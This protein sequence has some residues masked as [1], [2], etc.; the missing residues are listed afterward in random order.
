MAT[1]YNTQINDILE[2]KWLKNGIILSWMCYKPKN[3]EK[4]TFNFS[5]SPCIIADQTSLYPDLMK[6][7]THTHT[8]AHTQSVLL[9]LAPYPEYQ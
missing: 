8:H 6:T 5:K 3:E 4:L 9:I 1:P 7:N 2:I